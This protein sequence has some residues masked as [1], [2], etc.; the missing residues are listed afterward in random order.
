MSNLI[1]GKE[2]WI[3]AVSGEDVQYNLG[4]MDWSDLTDRELNYWQ[5]ER[6]LNESLNYNFR[7]KPRTITLNG[8]EVSAPF[9]PKED[10][11]VFILDDSYSDGYTGY[12]YEVNGE[13]NN[14]FLGLWRTEEE[15]KQVVE[16]LRSIFK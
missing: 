3:K 16:A 1:S 13:I 12:E 9:E 4:G 15:I 11:T 5:G 10:C 2:A 7:L 14:K 8:I 6:F